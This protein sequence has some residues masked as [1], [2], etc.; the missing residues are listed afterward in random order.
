[1]GG[2]RGPEGAGGAWSSNLGI[3]T[4]LMLLA[5]TG[6]VRPQDDY[7]VVRTPGAP[8]Y[9]FGNLLVLHAR[10]ADADRA[11]LEADFCERVGSPPLIRHRTFL[12]PDCETPVSGLEAYVD[13]G[14]DVAHCCVLTAEAG[15]LQGTATHPGVE[16]RPF[17]NQA[18]WDQWAAM[19]VADHGVPS[20]DDTFAR[21][22]AHQQA[23]YK[24]LIAQGLGDW[25]GAYLDGQQVGSLGLFGFDGLARFHSVLT[26]GAHRNRNICRTL[27]SEVAARARRWA[28]TLVI[29]ADE[30][31]HAG[32]IYEGMGFRRSQWVTSLCYEPPA[33]ST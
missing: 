9:Y 29:V 18:D 31:H 4:D 20:A 5:Q 25:W 32:R 27:V 12:W 23:A 8:E 13:A 21:Y 14:Y 19:H 1:M 6:I 16:V 22:L 30:R 24:H 28:H 2:M 15:G 11:R 17:R 10:P 3:A 33:A 26:A 7:I